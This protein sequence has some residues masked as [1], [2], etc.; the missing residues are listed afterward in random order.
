MLTI[1]SPKKQ[2]A[3][4]IAVF[5]FL[6]ALCAGWAHTSVP[7]GG[8][9]LVAY[10]GAGSTEATSVGGSKALIYADTLAVKVVAV[11]AVVGH[12]GHVRTQPGNR[13]PSSQSGPSPATSILGAESELPG[14]STSR[15]A[16]EAKFKH[17]ADFGVTEPRGAAGFDTFGKAVDS[18][19]QDPATT[20]IMG[21][22]RGDLRS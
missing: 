7:P 13:R 11:E 21:T 8:Q 5:A 9:L 19:V 1:S 10:Q 2:L 16:L 20:R 22:Y 15:S 6:L 3:A 12:D 18:F 17:A 14:L 4:L